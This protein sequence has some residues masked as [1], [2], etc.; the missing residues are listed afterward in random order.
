MIPFLYAFDLFEGPLIIPV[1]CDGFQH[2]GSTN[3]VGTKLN[4]DPV[5]IRIAVVLYR[6]PGRAVK[7]VKMSRL[8]FF[9][10]KLNTL[11]E[12]IVFVVCGYV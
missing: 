7:F 3:P 2:S 6:F 11:P 10:I 5:A 12:N 9:E 4:V 1:G 8:E